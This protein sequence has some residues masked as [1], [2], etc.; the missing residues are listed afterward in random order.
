[1]LGSQE[2]ILEPKVNVKFFTVDPYTPCNRVSRPFLIWSIWHI[3]PLLGQKNM[4]VE[5]VQFWCQVCLSLYEV[6]IQAAGIYS[7]NIFNDFFIFILIYLLS[8]IL[9]LSEVVIAFPFC[10]FLVILVMKSISA[11]ESFSFRMAYLWKSSM[12]SSDFLFLKSFA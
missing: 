10:R 8:S 1:M 6:I 4:Y 3:W 11:I 2:K 5:K 9:T 7:T 12:N